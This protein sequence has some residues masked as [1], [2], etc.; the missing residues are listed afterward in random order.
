MRTVFTFLL[1]TMVLV[2]C[3]G[4]TQANYR[5]L[6]KLKKGHRIYN[7]PNSLGL[8]MTVMT[9]MDPGLCVIPLNY[10]LFVTGLSSWL[11]KPDPKNPILGA[12]FLNSNGD[13]AMVL[14]RLDR[15]RNK[16]VVQKAYSLSSP[17][18]SKN[19]FSMPVS[20]YDLRVMNEKNLFLWGEFDGGSALWKSDYSAVNTVFYTSSVIRDMDYINEKNYVLALDSSVVGLGDKKS[21][22]VLVQ[23]DLPVESV[24]VDRLNSGAV[25]VSTRAG[26]VRVNSL[27]E[28]DMDVIT[29]GIHGKLTI[30]QNRLFILWAEKNQIVEITL[31]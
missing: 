12:S 6:I 20:R 1:S 5:E 4:Q 19:L 2:N 29:T 15:T 28:E 3:F 14:L 23:F 26:V 30:Y 27:E 9:V 18:G 16:V 17:A 13:T 31:K 8:K 22:E 25:Y 7:Y 21:P 24:A 10:G 11:A